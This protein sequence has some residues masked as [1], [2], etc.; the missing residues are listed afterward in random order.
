M[1]IIKRVWINKSKN[2][3]L[4]TIPKDVNIKPGD[5][6]EVKKVT[7]DDEAI[8]NSRDIFRVKPRRSKK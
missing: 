4:I 3:K 5:F 7:L 8:Y 2:Q 1:K 6:V